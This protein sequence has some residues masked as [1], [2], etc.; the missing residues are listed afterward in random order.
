[1]ATLSEGAFRL[2]SLCAQRP[3]SGSI[4]QQLPSALS[5][6]QSFDELANAAEWHGMEPLLLA[7]LV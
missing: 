7:H 6:V 4:A 3:G 5:A 2:L 1:M